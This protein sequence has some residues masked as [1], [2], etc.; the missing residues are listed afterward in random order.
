MTETKLVSVKIPAHVLQRM[1]PAGKGRS[2]FI[3]D[4]LE[5]KISR[6]SSPEWKPKTERGRRLAALLEKGRR[7]RAPFLDKEGIARELAERR[8][9]WH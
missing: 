8:G 4:A 5:E 9:R 3:I 6:R 1:P 7:E 2:R